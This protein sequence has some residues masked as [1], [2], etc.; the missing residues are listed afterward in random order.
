MVQFDEDDQIKRITNLRQQE[1]EDVVSMLAEQQYQMPYVNLM[2]QAIDNDAI[3]L[4]TEEQAR[5]FDVGPY[6][7][8]DKK[9]YLAV[10]SPNAPNA[11]KAK[12][13]IE[14]NGYEVVMVMASEKSI[15]KVW[16]HYEDLSYATRSRAGGLDISPDVLL[17][18]SQTVKTM[19]DAKKVI[20]DAIN[21]SG[22]AHHLSRILEIIIGAGI[23]IGASDVHV[24]PMEKETELR[25]R[26]DG[27]LH[28]ITTFGFDTYK[29]INTRIKLLS[30]LKLTINSNPQD[31]RFSA[32]LGEDE[33]SFRTSLIPGAYGESIVLRILNPKS[34]RV[35]LDELGISAPLLDIFIKGIHKPNGMVLLTG[36]TGSGK[37]TTLYAFLQKVYSPELKI[38]TIEDPIEYHLNGITQTQ[39]DHKKGYTFLE[40]LRSALRQDPDIIMVGEI[41]DSETAKIAVESALTGH[42]VFSTLHTNNASGVIPRLID[43]DVNPKILVSALSLSIAQR[44]VRKLCTNCKHERPITPEEKSTVEEI[45]STAVANGKNMEQF[46]V[47][48]DVAN[49]WSADGCDKCGHTGYKGR[50]G[51]FE[52]VQMDANIEHIILQNPTERDIKA[53]ADKQGTLDMREDGIVKILQGI[54]DFAEVQSVVDLSP[55]K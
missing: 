29:Q 41:R 46:G 39:V 48:K 10:R 21:E 33:I 9:I 12:E 37:T 17:N 44:L 32:F 25:F 1:E 31:G 36:P 16:T 23:G 42:I 15:Q 43:L 51:I 49:V 47:K 55:E 54:T 26:L 14:G 3:R 50:L 24:E 2:S 20:D 35:Q 22:S 5:A 45:W 34:I 40:G 4:L 13:F 53:I 8:V 6:K 19:D 52:V 38:I 30:G 7:L 27:V 11:Q 28:V 18:L